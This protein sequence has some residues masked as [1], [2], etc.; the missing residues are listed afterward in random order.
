MDRRGFLRTGV[1]TG[2]VFPSLFSGG[3]FSSKLVEF[4]SRFD[5]VEGITRGNCPEEG[6]EVYY[7]LRPSRYDADFEEE[8]CD[9]DIQL[10]R[11][12]YDCSLSCWP[13][14]LDYVENEPFL[15]EVVWRRDG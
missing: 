10:F 8:L 11:G 6:G 9:L 14:S 7:F 5:G 4:A 3:Y 2:L 12:G 1:G 13:A 15:G